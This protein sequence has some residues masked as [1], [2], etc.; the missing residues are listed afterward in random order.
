MP[1]EQTEPSSRRNHTHLA[2]AAASWRRP[3][4]YGYTPPL[5]ESPHAHSSYWLLPGLPAH[6]WRMKQDEWKIITVI[7]KIFYYNIKVI[8][9]ISYNNVK[10]YAF[11]KIIHYRHFQKQVF[12]VT[13]WPYANSHWFKQG[14]WRLQVKLLFSKDLSLLQWKSFDLDVKSGNIEKTWNVSIGHGCPR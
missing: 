10:I 5:V 2:L 1:Y 11:V 13:Y 8:S 12:H 6:S 7:S 3:H 4:R 14:V 9:F